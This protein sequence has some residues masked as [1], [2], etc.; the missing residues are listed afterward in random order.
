VSAIAREIADRVGQERFDLWFHKSTKLE[1]S[2]Q[3]LIVQVPNRFFL[4]WLKTQYD[5]MLRDV[6][7][8]VCGRA[9]TVQF[10]VDESLHGPR[11]EDPPSLAA[12]PLNEGDRHE[13]KPRRLATLEEYV[14]G[15]CNQLAYAAAQRVCEH[16]GREFQPLFIHGGVGLGK[17]HLL[18]GICAGLR[19]RHR[20]MRVAY[21]TAE[22][23]TN[24]F[25]ASLRSG[26][27]PSFRRKH[28]GVHAL[29]VDEVQFLAEK[30]A[31]QEEF[32][33]TFKCLESAGR[34]VIVAADVHPRFLRWHS[35]E[36]ASRVAAGM[37]CALD[38]PDADTRVRILQAQAARTKTNVP[39]GV[40]R[41]VAE[42]ITSNVREL[43]GALNTLSAYSNL[44]GVA[45]DLKTAK[46]VLSQSVCPASRRVR[47]DDIA[48][49]VCSLFGL[50]PKTLKS[51]GRTRTVSRPRM[52]AMYLARKHTQAAL[53][54][55]GRFFGGRNHSTVISAQKK[56]DLWLHGDA[57]LSLSETAW[58]MN[59][60]IEHL[61]RRLCAS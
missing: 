2:D 9:M 1:L 59:E 41:Y 19:R 49:E 29:I 6:A 57:S 48:Q 35:A 32:L 10:Q 4:E 21:L 24:D 28:R 16:P 40:L 30:R 27:L 45:L 20:A 7:T 13:P 51:K 58:K 53:S 11:E 37:T 39:D 42:Q 22:E 26:S 33:H 17:T 56:V 8:H 18:E 3:Q 60:V 31:T 61:E 15:S 55:I 38:P 34:Q 43:E 5:P 44:M 25:L 54:E 46:T 52:I 47:L 36:L 12:P 23:F 50:D 14:T